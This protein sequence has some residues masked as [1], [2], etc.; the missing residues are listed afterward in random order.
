MFVGSEGIIFDDVTLAGFDIDVVK[1]F[2]DSKQSRAVKCRHEDGLIPAKTPRLFLTNHEKCHFF[3]RDAELTA[4]AVAINRRIRWVTVNQ[5]LFV[6]PNPLDDD[7]MN[8]QR[9][10]PEK[11]MRFTKTLPQAKAPANEAHPDC[12]VPDWDEMEFLDVTADEEA[13]QHMGL[14]DEDQTVPS[15]ASQ[16]GLPVQS[17]HNGPAEDKSSSSKDASCSVTLLKAN[18]DIDQGDLGNDEGSNVFCNTKSSPA[19]RVRRSPEKQETSALQKE[20]TPCRHDSRQQVFDSIEENGSKATNPGCEASSLNVISQAAD[21]DAPENNQNENTPADAD[22]V[23]A[24][25]LRIAT[26]QGRGPRLVRNRRK[27]NPI[28]L[29]PWLK[30]DVERHRGA[31]WGSSR[32]SWSSSSFQFYR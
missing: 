12:N 23:R 10:T 22:R 32:G 3:P 19:K 15:P 27:A 13:A 26:P 21:L 28:F 20:A 17:K 16:N 2:L 5:Q 14:D 1:S 31:E 29:P 18:Q 24:S 25:L 6:T 30:D 4:H 8:K 9:N 11:Q 7:M